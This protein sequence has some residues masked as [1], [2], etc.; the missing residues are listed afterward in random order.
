M[1][2][3]DTWKQEEREVC[4]FLGGPRRGPDTTSSRGDSSTG[5]PDCIHPSLSVEVKK[6]AQFP[7]SKLIAALEQSEENVEDGKIPIVV[8]RKNGA[9]KGDRL[10]LVRLSTFRDRLTE[11]AGV[12]PPVPPWETS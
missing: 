3:P 5:K 9:P 1:K 7:W 6:A 8:F 4:E 11:Y 12:V 2:N 10:V